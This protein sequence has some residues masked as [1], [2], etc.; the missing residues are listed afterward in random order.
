[1]PI[2]Y[3]TSHLLLLRCSSAVVTYRRP[4]TIILSLLALVS[5]LAACKENEKVSAA[6]PPTPVRVDTVRLVPP[7]SVA[8]FSGVVP[9]R[10]EADTG[11]R[12]GGKVVERSVD[13]GSL[14]EA[15]TMLAR[16]DPADLDLQ[17]RA[18]EAQL[19]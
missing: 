11:L 13:V 19:L 9:P 4:K 8:P 2:F 3:Q 7:N 6:P 5:L 10:M 15:G 14:V 17:V 16:L 1:M 12:C 18:A